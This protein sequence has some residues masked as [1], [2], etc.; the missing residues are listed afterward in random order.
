MFEDGEG[1]VGVCEVI[2]YIYKTRKN[3]DFRQ[4]FIQQ[5]SRL[6]HPTFQRI[7]GRA[8]KFVGLHL[9]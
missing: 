9:R 2:P 1:N 5:S 8:E 6:R 7:Y 4:A 3:L